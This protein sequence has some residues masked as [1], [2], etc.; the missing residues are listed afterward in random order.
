M[1]ELDDVLEAIASFFRLLAEPT[2]LKV[3]HTIC[4][5]ERSVGDIVAQTGL[6]QSNVSR[7]LRALHTRGVV[8]RRKDGASVFYRVADPTLVDLCRAV[9]LRIAAQIDE[10]RPLRRALRKF[11]PEASRSTRRAAGI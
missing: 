5:E 9:S 6:S 7:Q 2:R 4:D 1:S 11:M 8:S 3:L 10:R